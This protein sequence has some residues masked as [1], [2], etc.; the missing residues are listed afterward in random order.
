M[1]KSHEQI[2]RSHVSV[3]M[4]DEPRYYEHAVPPSVQMDMIDELAARFD[5]PELRV[6]RLSSGEVRGILAG[7]IDMY[8]EDLLARGYDDPAVLLRRQHAAAA[9]S[10]YS[11]QVEGDPEA[12]AAYDY[13]DESILDDVIGA[14][15]DIAD[16]TPEPRAEK[17]APAQPVRRLGR[18][19]AEYAHFD[20]PDYEAEP[21][22][23]TVSGPEDMADLPL[24]FRIAEGIDDPVAAILPTDPAERDE[25]LLTYAAKLG[26][27]VK[28]Y[29]DNHERNELA[30]MHKINHAAVLIARATNMLRKDEANNAAVINKLSDASGSYMGLWSGYLEGVSGKRYQTRRK[31]AVVGV[32]DIQSTGAEAIWWSML[33]CDLSRT[34]RGST[35]YIGR[36]MTGALTDLDRA[37]SPLTRS[38]AGLVTAYHGLIDGVDALTPDEAIAELRKQDPGI[39]KKLP[40]ALAAATS[41]STEL[42]EGTLAEIPDSSAFGAPDASADVDTI[43]IQGIT[44]QY[45][46]NARTDGERGRRE[47]DVSIILEYYLGEAVTMDDLAERYNVSSSRISQIISATTKGL[48]HLLPDELRT[49]NVLSLDDSVQLVR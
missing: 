44:Q 42:L 40:R 5:W 13:D 3:R 34:P 9:L 35:S 49:A 48:R 4:V 16:E 47:R 8:C 25:F 31:Y 41:F 19:A 15:G 11:L 43:S 10:L 33:N 45:I 6:A 12:L 37:V 17:P 39:D 7:V 28:Y 1:P 24:C 27:A 32:E 2:G 29:A 22:V 38:D 36:R 30:H 26:L 21:T 14:V 20:E 46:D 23:V 18:L